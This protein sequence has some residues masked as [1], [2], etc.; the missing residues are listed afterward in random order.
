MYIHILR[1]KEIYKYIY[2]YIERERERER[3][4]EKNMYMQKDI[5]GRPYPTDNSLHAEMSLLK[6]L[7]ARLGKRHLLVGIPWVRGPAA[8]E[9]GFCTACWGRWQC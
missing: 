6:L 1:E 7:L 2:I 9:E 5:K 3:E 8:H 4:R